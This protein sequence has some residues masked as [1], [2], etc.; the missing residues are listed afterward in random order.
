MEERTVNRDF[1][2][3][4]GNLCKAVMRMHNDTN[5]LDGVRHGCAFIH[6]YETKQKN[7]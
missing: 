1:A 3:P 2:S 5:K 4:D 6:K 7:Y